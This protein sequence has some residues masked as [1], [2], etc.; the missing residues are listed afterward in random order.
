M[1]V[2]FQ[3][4]KGKYILAHVLKDE[5]KEIVIKTANVGVVHVKLQIQSRSHCKMHAIK[6]FE[7]FL[8]LIPKKLYVSHRDDF[9]S[10]DISANTTTISW[11][12][13]FSNKALV[14]LYN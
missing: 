8:P 9:I 10:V 6:S 5:L 2:M 3:S 14:E 13:A 11:S 4:P 1:C 7:N 12:V